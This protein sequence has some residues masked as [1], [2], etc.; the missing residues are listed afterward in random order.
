MLVFQRGAGQRHRSLSLAE[1]EYFI[2]FICVVFLR[3]LLHT[4]LPMLEETHL[5]PPARSGDAGS[6]LRALSDERL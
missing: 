2:L 4:A 5:L 3:I 6:A 1:R